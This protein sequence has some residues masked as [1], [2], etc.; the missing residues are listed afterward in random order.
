MQL[1]SVVVRTAA[2]PPA[3]RF[4]RLYMAQA[5]HAAMTECGPEPV[6]ALLQ[7]IA[8]AHGSGSGDLSMANDDAII[9]SR[10]PLLLLEGCGLCTTTD[11]PTLLAVSAALAVVQAADARLVGHMLLQRP[12]AVSK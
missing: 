12:F 7:C 3:M 10:L 9:L 5:L 11:L 8:Q 1:L 2:D 6:V 4:G